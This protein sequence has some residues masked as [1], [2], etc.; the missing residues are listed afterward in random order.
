MMSMGPQ[1]GG[2]SLNT[3]LQPQLTSSS[4]GLTPVLRTASE[5][6]ELFAG[7]MTGP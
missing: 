4:L 6:S 5:L 3:R 1:K 7:V 2:A